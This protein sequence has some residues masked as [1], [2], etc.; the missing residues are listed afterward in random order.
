[1]GT[2]PIEVRYGRKLLRWTPRPSIKALLEHVKS[3]GD[4][5]QIYPDAKVLRF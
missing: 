4:R 3:T 5:A 2:K 1:M